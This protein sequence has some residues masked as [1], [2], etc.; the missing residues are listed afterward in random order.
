MV[1]DSFGD[2]CIAEFVQV[3]LCYW[4]GEFVRVVG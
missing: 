1:G 4:V 3:G 2:R